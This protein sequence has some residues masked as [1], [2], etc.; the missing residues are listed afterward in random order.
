MLAMP[1]ACALEEMGALVAGVFCGVL[2]LSIVSV[3][4][5]RTSVMWKAKKRKFGL[6][7]GISADHR[8]G[9]I[10]N[11]G[12]RC[13]RQKGEGKFQGKL[14][15]QCP[16]PARCYEWVGPSS[17]VLANDVLQQAEMAAVLR[18]KTAAN[19]AGC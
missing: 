18:K 11:A 6:K 3:A 12:Q 15:A 16:G 13:E 5:L 9:G 17:R 10:K 4:L 8:V 7:I 1:G 19:A 14:T 2:V